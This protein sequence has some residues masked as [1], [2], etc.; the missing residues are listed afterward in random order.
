[1]RRSLMTR[2]FLLFARL[3]IE[4]VSGFGT[5]TPPV[6][7]WNTVIYTI[8]ALDVRMGIVV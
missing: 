7:W 2:T 3:H 1:M 5:A 8:I 6:L 4:T